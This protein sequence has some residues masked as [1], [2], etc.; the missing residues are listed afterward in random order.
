MRQL[1]EYNLKEIKGGF[2][3]SVGLAVGIAAAVI[4]LCGVI[5]G[6]TNPDKCRT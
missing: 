2:D 3:M 6:I 5:E 1:N 4:F